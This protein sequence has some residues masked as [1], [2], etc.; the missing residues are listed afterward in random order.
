MFAERKKRKFY[1]LACFAACL[2]LSFGVAS[3]C[4]AQ[5]KEA[6]KARLYCLMPQA[7]SL[8]QSFVLRTE[9]GKLIVLDGGV[10]SAGKDEAAYMPAALR[11]IAGVGQN[12]YVEVEAWFLSHAHK[13]H[14][15]ELSKTLTEYYNDENFFV[16]NFYFDF[17][18]FNTEEYPYDTGDDAYL[19]V[20]SLSMDLYAEA[21]N[22]PVVG[23]SYYD[24]LNGAVINADTIANGSADMEIDGV[25]IEFLQTWDI[26]NGT[27]INDNS[28]IMRMWI[29]GQSVLFLSD[30]HTAAGESLLKKYGLKLQSDIVQMAHHGQRGVGKEVYDAVDAKVRIWN[31]PL[32]VWNNT[33]DYEIGTTRSWVNGG[34]DF[35]VGGKRDIVCC[36]YKKYPSNRTSVEAWKKVVNGMS[37]PLPYKYAEK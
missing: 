9:H 29:D 19:E 1:R 17:P 3:G 25:R 2:P 21:R 5:D 27:D 22:I 14:F 36:L 7:N 6:G 4:G 8:M 26:S 33:T 24:D 15:R 32:W 30:A 23:D 28:L 37:I 12:D 18:N 16:K 31:T 10:D 11:A 13:D 34:K 35:T 20:L